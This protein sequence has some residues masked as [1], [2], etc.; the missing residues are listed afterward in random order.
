MHSTTFRP[1]ASTAA[2]LF[3]IA[4][5]VTT[6]SPDAR[7]D[8]VAASPKG[9]VGGGLLGAEAVT[10]VESLAGVQPAWAYAVGAVVGAG[11]GA[12]GGWALEQ[13]SSDGQLPMYLLAGGLALVIPALVLTL[14]ATRFQPEPGATED[15]VPTGPAAEPG[16]VGG[17]IVAPSGAAPAPQPAPSQA[18]PPPAPPTPPQSLLDMKGGA[19]RIGVILP[20][21]RPVY[22][23]EQQRQYGLRAAT[24]LRLPVLH[25]TF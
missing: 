14:N 7:A 9:I 17:S 1:L 2:I 18:S 22:S 23:I 25:V 6:A 4:A 24:E 3:G 12:A 19:L 5:L 16:V 20:E 8:A 13:G 11:G 15:N 10:I 21:I